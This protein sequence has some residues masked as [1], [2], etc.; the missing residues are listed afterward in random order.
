MKD[1]LIISLCA[2]CKSC[3]AGKCTDCFEPG[4]LYGCIN[5]LEKKN[6]DRR[7]DNKR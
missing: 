2:E 1:E 5:F 7:N 6:E 4:V 3:V